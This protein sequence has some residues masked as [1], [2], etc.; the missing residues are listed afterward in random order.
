MAA[1]DL[2]GQMIPIRFLVLIRLM[3]SAWTV[4]AIAMVTALLLELGLIVAGPARLP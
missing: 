3:R 4:G 1:S 2:D